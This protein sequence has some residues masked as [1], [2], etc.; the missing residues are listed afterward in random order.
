MTYTRT[1]LTLD[2][3]LLRD[4]KK[5]AA[6]EKK[7]LKGIVEAALKT[8]LEQKVKIKRLTLSDFP[9]FNMGSVNKRL[10]KRSSL[11]QEN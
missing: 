4:A 11:Y 5:L 2:P 10:I 9:V 6:D 1:T 3:N 8:Y 7:P